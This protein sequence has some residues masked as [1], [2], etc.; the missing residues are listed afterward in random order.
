MSEWMSSLSTFGVG[1]VMAV[2]IFIAYERLVREVVEVVRGNTRAMESLADTI[3]GLR[4]QV[5]ELS[6]RVNALERR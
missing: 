1:A 3:N 6:K 4:D 2:L 5:S